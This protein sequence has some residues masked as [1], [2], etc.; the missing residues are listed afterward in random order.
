MGETLAPQIR[1]L[2]VAAVPMEHQDRADPSEKGAQD[3]ALLK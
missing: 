3:M 2:T 1:H